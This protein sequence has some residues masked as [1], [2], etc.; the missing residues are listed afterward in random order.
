MRD[1]PEVEVSVHAP[2]ALG[3]FALLGVHK[4]LHLL[5]RALAENLRRNREDVKVDLVSP[6]G[7][8]SPKCQETKSSE[9]LCKVPQQLGIPLGGRLE[10]LCVGARESHPGDRGPR[11]EDPIGYADH[12]VDDA[13]VPDVAQHGPEFLAAGLMDNDLLANPRFGYAIP[14]A[15]AYPVWYVPIRYDDALLIVAAP[16][17]PQIRAGTRK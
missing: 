17:I 9:V 15:R 2:V 12:R 16:F 14:P 7:A 6:R 8:Y 4:A 3:A 11:A 1:D 13:E 5:R 10:F